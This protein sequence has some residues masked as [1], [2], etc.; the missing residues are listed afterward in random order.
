MN[1]QLTAHPG[2][3]TAAP[4]LSLPD[5]HDHLHCALTQLLGVLPRP[6]S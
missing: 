4:A 6:R 5:L 3:L 1:T 2:Q